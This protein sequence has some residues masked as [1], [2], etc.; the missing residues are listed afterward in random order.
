MNSIT[1]LGVTIT[2]EQI[3]EGSVTLANSMICDEL[4]ADEATFTIISGEEDALF[5]SNLE[6]LFDSNNE[7]LLSASSIGIAIDLN[8]VPYGTPLT[9]S[10][11]GN[12]V[13]KFYTT[14]VRQLGAGIWQVTAQSAVG[15]LVKQEHLGGI[16]TSGDTVKS[17]IDE[18]MSG[19]SLTYTV[20]AEIQNEG[21][22]GWLPVASCRDNLQQLCFAFGISVLKDANGDLVFK[23]NEPDTPTESIAD[24]R[25]YM[26]GSKNY[27]SPATSV[28]VY[29][30]AYYEDTTLSPIVL[31]DN[32]G[33]TSVTNQRV[34]FNSP[35]IPSSYTVTGTLTVS[36]ITAN[37]AVIS[38]IGVLSAIEYAHVAKALT[39][40]TGAS[41]VEN[42]EVV[43][44]DATLVSA[45]NSFNCI[46]RV[47]EYYSLAYENEYD[48]V[49]D[50]EQTGEL[51]AYPDPFS[52]SSINGLIKSM[53]I[54]I[55][56]I[57][58]ARARL[59]ENWLPR[60]LGNDF[61]HYDVYSATGSYSIPAGHVRLIIIGGGTGGKGGEHAENYR[62]TAFEEVGSIIGPGADGGEGGEGGN[63]HIVDLEAVLGDTITITQIGQGGLGG[64]EAT[65]GSAGTD[66]ILTH[67]STTYTSASGSPLEYG[68]V[69]PLSGE[70]FARKGIHGVKGADGG[71]GGANNYG[72]SLT[73]DGVTYSGGQG[74]DGFFVGSERYSNAGGSGAAYK[75][76]GNNASSEVPRNAGAGVTPPDADAPT[77]KGG[78]GNG[79]HGGSGHGKA[80]Y[81][82][83]GGFNV[84]GGG[85]SKGSDGAAGCVIVLS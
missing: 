17:V 6:Q 35:V 74:I 54:T 80:L 5:D 62:W 52:S 33:E 38:G 55:S 41:N 8:N 57:L 13:G 40:T 67:N 30:H 18:I 32:T 15:L 69:N 16:Y 85:G 1:L 59:T 39:M 81:D 28:T 61:S 68:Y 53:D 14:Q 51:V 47:A 79:G 20:D 12:I 65:A 3:I 66:T 78:G 56:G 49:M 37:Y 25:L 58:K 73:I 83:E 84:N 45:L 50:N 34:V 11:D 29:E 24:G 26:G 4:S 77:I 64:L 43:Y 9:Y 19:L 44:K 31:F 2:D 75:T 72:G 48:F 22:L 63:V 36:E 7:A 60:Y 46:N 71:D 70:V 82:S 21:V 10:H 27:L 42:R 23:Y 76:P